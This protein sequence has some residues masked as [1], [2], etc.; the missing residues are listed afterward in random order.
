MSFVFEY[1]LFTLDRSSCGKPIFKGDTFCDD[2]NNNEGCDWDGGDCCGDIVKTSCSTCQYQCL[3]P[4]FYYGALNSN[5]QLKDL[6]H[7]KSVVMDF[8]AKYNVEGSSLALVKDGRLVYSQGFG[9]MEKTLNKPVQATSLFR[10]ASLSKPITSAVLMMM[11][12]ENLIKLES[13]IFGQNGVLGTD[14]GTQPYSDYEKQI[15]LQHL[16]EHTAGGLSWANNNFDPYDPMFQHLW[17]YDFSKLI[18]WVLDTR[19][20]SV[21]PGTDYAYSNFGYCVLG[22]VIEKIS[23][24]SYES[25]VQQKILNPIGATLTKIG[26]SKI[27]EKVKYEVTYYDNNSPYYPNLNVERMDAHGGWISSS[28]DLARFLVHF[29]GLSSKPDLISRSTYDLMVTPSSQN[30]HYAKGW[31]VNSLHNIWH[32]GSLPGTGS[33]FFSSPSK[34]ICAVFLMNYRWKDDIDPMLWDIING[35]ENWPSNLDLFSSHIIDT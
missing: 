12:E 17:D 7:I 20:P 30:D 6:N 29:D 32:T 8:M 19:D 11:I 31:S 25:Y 26:K 28:V 13:K 35:I 5:W 24:Q 18:G 16:L 23:G 1:V 9:V 3:D 21:Q 22:R 15:T 4:N 33:M 2:E 34:G 14:Y 10:I 27:S